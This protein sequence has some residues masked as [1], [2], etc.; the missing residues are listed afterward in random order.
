[1]R[2]REARSSRTFARSARSRNSP[3]T[4]SDRG[5]GPTSLGH[6][7]RGLHA[8]VPV[9]GKDPLALVVA[10]QAADLRLRELQA[11]AV[12]RVLLVHLQVDLEA[13]GDL[14]QRREVLGRLEAD[15]L[16]AEDLEEGL[17]GDEPHARDAVLVA[18]LQ[19]DGGG[20]EDLAGPLPGAPP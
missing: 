14:Q 18:E 1:M 17:P 3:G 10:R 11:A 19:T 5:T 8:V 15:A 13:H 9:R 2:T 16:G 4:R 6:E 7:L 12:V 20:G